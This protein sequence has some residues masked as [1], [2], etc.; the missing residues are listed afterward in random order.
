MPDMIDKGSLEPLV[1]DIDILSNI[2]QFQ[3]IWEKP[4]YTMVGQWDVAKI[5]SLLS[6]ETI[7][8]LQSLFVFSVF[9]QGGGLGDENKGGQRLWQ[10]SA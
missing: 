4:Y 10:R 5:P 6:N 1:I 3:G 7:T 2:I 8:A 9:I